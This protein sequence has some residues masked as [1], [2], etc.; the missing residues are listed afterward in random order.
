MSGPPI[1]QLLRGPFHFLEPVEEEFERRLPEWSRLLP[2]PYPIYLHDETSTLLHGFPVLVTDGLVELREALNAFLE[3]EE[4]I[5]LAVIRREPLL[6]TAHN[7]S[8]RR[9]RD[10]L[11]RA[12]E[13]SLLSS[14]GR[15]YSTLFW[16][17]HSLDVSRQLRDT[18]RR[19]TRLDLRL[20]QK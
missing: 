1:A 16:L 11:V 8:W 17:H 2:L 15:N 3:A 10:Q 7:A 5:Q 13:N 12:I 9:Y 20:G 4:G 6:R 18:P 14:Y 19:I